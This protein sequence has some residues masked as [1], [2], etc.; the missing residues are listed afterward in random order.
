MERH[1]NALKV[2]LFLQT[3]DL[4]VRALAGHNG[5]SSSAACLTAP[6][7]DSSTPSIKQHK[8]QSGF[9]HTFDQAIQPT[10]RIQNPPVISSTVHHQDSNTQLVK[11]QFHNQCFSLPTSKQHRT[12]LGL[13]SKCDQGE[14]FTKQD[15]STPVVKAELV[16]DRAQVNL[17]P[18]T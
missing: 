4:L 11:Q 6:A 3:A 1:T 8:L 5:R 12:Q 16:T 15:S 2:W 7:Q 13:D 17:R 9:W 10:V 18:S 14:L